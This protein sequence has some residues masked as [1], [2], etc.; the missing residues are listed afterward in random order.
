MLSHQLL[1]VQITTYVEISFKIA[2][3]FIMQ[4]AFFKKKRC[5]INRTIL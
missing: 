3:E 2:N 4:V 5:S 1:N